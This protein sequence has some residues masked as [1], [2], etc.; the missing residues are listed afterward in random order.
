MALALAAP[1]CVYVCVHNIHDVTRRTRPQHVSVRPRVCLGSVLHVACLTGERANCKR[2]VASSTF[3]E[4]NHWQTIIIIA[5]SPPR[6]RSVTSPVSRVT[7]HTRHTQHTHSQ[8]ARI[9]VII[10]RTWAASAH[11]SRSHTDSSGLQR[12]QTLHTHTH[13]YAQPSH[14]HTHTCSHRVRPFVCVC[15]CMCVSARA[16]AETFRA[17]AQRAGRKRAFA[18]FTD[19]RRRADVSK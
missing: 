1:L 8:F 16:R 9:C 17:K 18:A 11:L 3:G 15:A 13:V 19:D 2:V 12:H 6:R 14:K 5:R 10:S 4:Y 7:T